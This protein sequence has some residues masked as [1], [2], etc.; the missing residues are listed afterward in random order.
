MFAL[1]TRLSRS[2]LA[3]VP[4]LFAG[5]CG[6][7]LATAEKVPAPT[8][9]FEAEL[10][11]GYLE[12]SRSEYNEGDYVDADR[13]ALRSMA[14][15]GGMPRSPEAIAAR[16]LPEGMISEMS[17]ARSR[18]TSAIDDD[19]RAQAPGPAARAQV[20]FDCWMQEQEENFQPDDIARCRSG[21]DSAMADIDAAAQAAAQ[22]EMRIAAV[23][24]KALPMDPQDPVAPRFYT[25]LFD[26]DSA[27]LNS[28]A[29]GIVAAIISDWADRIESLLLVG[30]ADASGTDEYNQGLSERRTT[31]V[32]NALGEGGIA[33]DRVTAT[34]VGES[35]L[36]VP[37]GDGVRELRNRRVTV[38]VE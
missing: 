33:D 32:K 35:D 11:A 4:I 28:S 2:F 37:T 23:Q 30:H 8:G 10:H 7:K 12:L 25:V 9:E 29:L 38:T 22:E 26:F 3:I 16:R 21:F 20:M 36:A 1:S 18:L 27:M 34:A 15:A 17:D 31:A 24:P 13:F 6:F 19:A 14:A 5:G